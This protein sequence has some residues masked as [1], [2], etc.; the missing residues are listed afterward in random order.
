MA[1][2]ALLIYLI[3][4]ANSAATASVAE[5][6]PMFAPT[7]SAGVGEVY[8]GHGDPYA[9]VFLLFGL[10]IITAAVGRFAAAKLRQSPVLGEVAAGIIVGALLYQL[11]EP[12]ITLIRHSDLVQQVTQSVQKENVGLEDAVRQ[13]LRQASL[14]A[15]E[16]FQVGQVLLRSDVGQLYMAADTLQ[17]FSS[18]GVVLLLFLVG[19]ECSL[20]EMRAVGGRA[21]AV[22]LIAITGI[23]LIGYLALNFILLPAGNSLSAL[24]MAAAL[25]ATSI[26]ITARVFRDMNRLGM[27]EAKLVL[28]AAVVDDI[29]GL[30]LL[31]V[32][33]GIASGGA[34]KL[35]TVAV[36][37][38]KA[39][40]FLA[41]VVLVGTL[42]LNRLVVLFAFVDRGNVRLIFPFALLMVLAFLADELGLA[43]IIGAFAAGLIIEEKY[44]PQDQQGQFEGRSVESVMSPFQLLFAPIFFVLIGMRVDVTTFANLKVLLTSLVLVIIIAT[45]KS[46]ASLAARKGENRLAVATGMLPGGEVMLIYAA[47]GKSLGLLNDNLYSIIIIVM[48]LTTLLTPPLLKWAIERLESKVALEG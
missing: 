38:F 41:G 22:A 25:T 8:G 36:I 16:A 43:S 23:L 32:V 47:L 28:G 7:S 34:V 12:I 35:S 33:T 46:L 13:V 29:L 44:F 19:L 21:T 31:A 11:G 37:F 4:G 26:G 39:V 3:A 45:A 24:F 10:F 14:P 40:L 5:V 27:S 48:L 17:L 9:L 2:S 30:V 15:P 6:S 20:K 18:L 1:V 42:L